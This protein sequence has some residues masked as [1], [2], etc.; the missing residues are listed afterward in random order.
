MIIYTQHDAETK[1]D[2]WQLPVSGGAAR[3]LLKT[4]YNEAQ[5]RISPNGRWIAY[6][7]RTAPA[8][9]GVCAAIP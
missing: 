2:L 8:L 3:P 4:G 5:A 9:G 6:V 1:L 7:P